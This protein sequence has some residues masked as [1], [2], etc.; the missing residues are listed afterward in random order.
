MADKIKTDQV[1]Y[2][3]DL[4]RIRLSED[5]VRLFSKQLNKILE[6]IDKLN[7]LDTKAVEP[8]SHTL[9]ITNVSREDKI[10]KS[11]DTKDVLA[12]APS[13]KNGFFQV[14]KVI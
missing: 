11:L 9:N 13:A 12:N 3:A 6:Y 10:K 8:M 14:P 5:E 2:V 1:K 4:A 7:Q